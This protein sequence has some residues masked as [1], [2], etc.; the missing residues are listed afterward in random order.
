MTIDPLTNNC[1]TNGTET[2]ECMCVTEE[3]EES[4]KPF[5]SNE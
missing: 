3:V 2:D 1:E 5:N 4:L